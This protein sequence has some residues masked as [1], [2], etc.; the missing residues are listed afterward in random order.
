MYNSCTKLQAKSKKS[1]K[2]KA[3]VRLNVVDLALLKA[4][5]ATDL[6]KNIFELLVRYITYY[7]IPMLKH[8][9]IA[10]EI[11]CSTKSVQRLM[12]KLEDASII[13]QIR[14]YKTLEDGSRYEIPSCYV[15]NPSLRKRSI[16][17]E[18]TR[19]FTGL[20]KVKA[21]SFLWL[22]IALLC[23]DLQGTSSRN[24]Y[25]NNIYIPTEPDY[26]HLRSIESQVEHEGRYQTF[27]DDFQ[28]D[29]RNFYGE[30]AP[31]AQ[32]SVQA[33]H[34]VETANPSFFITKQHNSCPTMT[35][36]EAQDIDHSK[37]TFEA[38]LKESTMNF[39][40]EQL[41]ELAS[42]PTEAIK[43]ADT[44]Y[45]AAIAAGKPVTNVFNY[46]KAV[47]Q[48]YMD[49]Q[50]KKQ[51]AGARTSA[52]SHSASKGMYDRMIQE[53]EQRTFES[54]ELPMLK[55][56]V[57]SYSRAVAAASKT[58]AR[59]RTDVDFRFLEDAQTQLKYFTRKIHETAAAHSIDLATIAI[60]EALPQPPSSHP[61]VQAF[62]AYLG[63]IMPDSVKQELAALKRSGHDDK[64]LNNPVLEV[65]LKNSPS[66]EQRSFIDNDS[67]TGKPTI[68]K[69]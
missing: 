57:D 56:Q 39:T 3:F 43:H 65:I 62:A 45:K 26:E 67:G 48:G 27:G 44:R 42:Y 51:S 55:K 17:L 8:E 25:S 32:P 49:D 15:I 12:R 19:Y 34:A 20:L 47:A 60:P 64:R 58:Y 52:A 66:H 40:Q 29:L 10:A 4:I 33:S 63:N 30:Q 35:A 2:L 5:C 23:S 54:Y 68:L 9:T 37:N 22:P 46:Y 28:D 61:D 38:R 14:Q 36:Y 41:T 1:P 16:M 11:G 24:L 69:Q 18:L 7:R 13:H 6:Q 21:L 31:E 50:A 59:T 53:R